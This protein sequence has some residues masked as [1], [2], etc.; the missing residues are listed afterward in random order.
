MDD[1][2]EQIRP[3]LP[4]RESES[5]PTLPDRNSPKGKKEKSK[6]TKP[7]ANK[8]KNASIPAADP[9]RPQHPLPKTAP[10]LPKRPPSSQNNQSRDIT[11]VGK[12]RIEIKNPGGTPKLGRSLGS[13]LERS[14]ASQEHAVPYEETSNDKK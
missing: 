9:A 4:P 10:L 2:Y 13:S 5:T 11:I 6:A 8:A 14:S 1:I 12:T 3:D 7:S